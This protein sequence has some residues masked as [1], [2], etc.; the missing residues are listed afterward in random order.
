MEETQLLIYKHL[1]EAQKTAKT[2]FRQGGAGRR[3]FLYSLPALLAQVASSKVSPSCYL[4]ALSHCDAETG[5]RGLVRHCPAPWWGRQVQMLTALSSSLS[6]ASTCTCRAQTLS[7]Y[8]YISEAYSGAR[9]RRSPAALLQMATV[10]CPST[11]Q[12]PQ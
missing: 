2:L 10:P 1:L 8:Q 4:V 11:L 6:K 3:L 5:E 7:C 12:R 9:S